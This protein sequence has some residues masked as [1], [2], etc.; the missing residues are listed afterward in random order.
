[1]HG[2]FY[3]ERIAVF[4][5]SDSPLNLARNIVTNLDR[6]GFRGEVFPIGR[7]GESLNGRKIFR[8]IEEVEPVPDIAVMLVP[9]RFVPEAIESCGRKGVKYVVIQS[10]GFTE[11][12]EASRD[13]ESRVKEVAR[14]WNIRFVGPNCISIINMENSL[15]LPFVP[16]YPNETRRG[17][18]SVAAQSG[19][20]MLEMMQG[21]N[22][23]GIGFNK[24]ISMGNKL[25]L[26]END[27]LE[28][29]ISDQ[30][31]KV[32]GLY[33]ENISDGRRLMELAAATDKPIVVLKSNTS[34]GG[35]RVAQFHTTALAGDDQV[36]SAG[37]AQAGIHR[38]HNLQEMLDDLKILSIA[39]MRGG[40]LGIL[41]RSGGHAVLLADA[42]HRYGF[43]LAAFSEGFFDRIRREV[44]AGVISMTNP[45]D[46]GDIFN[47]AFYADIVES[48]LQEEGVDGVVISHGAIS[49]NENEAT[50]EV[51]RRAGELSRQYGKP[52][53]AVTA[54]RREEYF[55]TRELG[56]PVFPEADLAIRAMSLSRARNMMKERKIARAGRWPAL[57]KSRRG[58]SRAASPAEAYGF[59]KSCGLPAAR[60]AVV[61][62][63]AEGLK[64]AEEI[65]YPVVLKIGD[66]GVIHKTEAGG[67]R[68]GIRTPAALK[69][70][71]REMSRASGA[72]EFLIQETAPAGTEVILGGRQDRE[73]GPVILFGLGGIFVEVLRD[74][75]LRVAPVSAE[76]AGDM[77]RGIRGR[78]LLEGFRGS[79]PCDTDSLAKYIEKLSLLLADHPEISNI[80][81][82][83]LIL[84]G[85][86]G[87]GIIVDAKMEITEKA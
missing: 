16:L 27:Y 82:N 74:V 43:E 49:K 54:P 29:L 18:V 33:L 34:P 1:M 77:I 23:E 6:F 65:G 83:P 45:L 84:Y 51:F 7:E 68:I 11:F 59:L 30:E 61:N 10:G 35:S 67:V 37:M 15:I 40:R 46:M 9:A 32:V 24:L 48:A 53:V 42:A 85:K 41:S 20:I 3:P 63:P 76:E 38:A 55:P 25:D 4:G 14:K 66:P 2:L 31:T 64:A 81:I 28:Y 8:S 36:A 50:R 47:I 75:A 60:F 13:L 58:Q 79:P 73:F 12:A 86:G 17:P 19:G 39:P 69:R 62:G 70:A 56:V 5:V 87:G 22:F 57:N 72:R 78:A 21:L 52:V 80:D 26:N 44:R 71:L